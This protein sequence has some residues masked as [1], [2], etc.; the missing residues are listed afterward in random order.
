MAA[1]KRSG[2]GRA[3]TRGVKDLSVRKSKNVK[4]GAP[5]P[6]GKSSPSDFNFTH[7]YDKSSPVLG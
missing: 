5:T 3:A 6:K 2:K 1:K 7:L 4:G